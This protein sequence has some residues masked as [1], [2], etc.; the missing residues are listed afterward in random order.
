MWFRCPGAVRSEFAKQG[1][2]LVR[3]RNALVV[4]KAEAHG[5]S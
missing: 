2:L 4:I 1:F 5:N 3:L